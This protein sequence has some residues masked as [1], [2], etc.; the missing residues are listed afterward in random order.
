MSISVVWFGL[1]EMP[2]WPPI[3]TS[4]RRRGPRWGS[5][6][7]DLVAGN[8]NN[9]KRQD[10]QAVNLLIF[11]MVFDHS[12]LILHFFL[13]KQMVQAKYEEHYIYRN[14]TK[15]MSPK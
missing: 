12:A 1:L 7:L 13:V 6:D 15:P 11:N 2:F 4:T 10:C 8:K 14:F 9:R 5:Q 3:G